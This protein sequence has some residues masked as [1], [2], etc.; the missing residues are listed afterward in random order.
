MNSEDWT[1]LFFSGNPPDWISVSPEDQKSF[2]TFHHK[3]KWVLW[4]SVDK[5]RYP[6][7][8]RIQVLWLLVKYHQGYRRMYVAKVFPEYTEAQARAQLRRIPFSRD[9][10]QVRDELDPFLNEAQVFRR[11]EER[12]D[13]SR[14]IYFPQFHGVVTDIDPSTF[15]S[16]YSNRRAI[17]LEAIKPDLSSRR[18]LAAH[19]RDSDERVARFHQRVRDI[20][21]SLS[22]FESDYYSSLFTDRVHRLDALHDLAIIHGDIRDDHFRLPGDFYDTV[23]YDFSISYTFSPIPPYLVNLRR[24]RSLKDISETEQ[25]F[26]AEQVYERAQKRDLRDHLIQSTRVAAEVIEDAL[27]QP[28]QDEE[29]ELVIL[30]VMTRPDA[31]SMPSL[32]SVFPFLATICPQNDP[33]WHIRKGRQLDHYAPAWVFLGRS[34]NLSNSVTLMTIGHHQAPN[35]GLLE[36]ESGYYL[37]CLIPKEWEI[38]GIH[39]KLRQVCSSL[40]FSKVWGY[41]IRRIEFDD[42][43]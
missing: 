1:K 24:P 20:K 3:R 22:A 16:G 15:K 35:V 7:P 30:K 38:D 9:P 39:N 31:F 11:I 17:I 4:K 29:L 32:S 25:L 2:R 6:A 14:K 28:L 37:L 27:F 18:I 23:L 8:D 13:S 34:G 10:K 41:I 12:C 26:L 19:N 40:E 42:H 43:T 36:N 5:G 21:P 33:T